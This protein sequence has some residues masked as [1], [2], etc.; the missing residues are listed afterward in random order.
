M[1]SNA[2]WQFNLI[3][4]FRPSLCKTC[5]SLEVRDFAVISR[6]VGRHEPGR[7][8]ITFFSPLMH[9]HASAKVQSSNGQWIKLIAEGRKKEAEGISAAKGI[10]CYQKIERDL[11][12]AKCRNMQTKIWPTNNGVGTPTP[13]TLVYNLGTQD[14]S[15]TTPRIQPKN[16]TPFPD[17]G[18]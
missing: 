15:R 18:A 13:L 2:Y 14:S 8:P 12:W 10:T 9:A 17:K 1:N 16:A 5:K 6:E 4:N 7:L 11:A 3:L